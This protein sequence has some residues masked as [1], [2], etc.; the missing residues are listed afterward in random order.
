MPQATFA[1]RILS[2]RRSHKLG[3]A[4]KN[5][6]EHTR[7]LTCESKTSGE[8]K[9]WMLEVMAVMKKAERTVKI[10]KPDEEI[11]NA[12]VMTKHVHERWALKSM[13]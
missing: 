10:A 12:K 6:C 8:L 1:G 5:H 4:V 7:I 13:I 3:T 9:L 2:C 11:R